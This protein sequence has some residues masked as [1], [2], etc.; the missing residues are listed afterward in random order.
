MDKDLINT[1]SAEVNGE[2]IN[3]LR[4]IENESSE[5]AEV[6]AAEKVIN[7]MRYYRQ[8]CLMK[9]KRR[10]DA[11]R[12]L[13]EE[14]KALLV[15]S[16]TE[17]MKRVRECVEQN[18]KLLEMIVHCGANILGGS[19]QSALEAHQ[20]HPSTEHY[21]TKSKSIL[22][23]L[24]RDWSANGAHERE[25][26]YRLVLNDMATLYPYRSNDNQQN[27]HDI[28]VLVTGA[29]LAR[30]AWE[31]RKMGFSVTG[32]E[33]FSYFMLLTSNFILNACHEKEEFTIYPYVMDFSNSWCYEDQLK[34]IKFP[35]VNPA[36]F[37]DG[38]KNSSERE[39]I[40]NMATGFAMCAGDFLQAYSDAEE[41]FDSV[42]SVFFLD[43]AANP[44]AYIRLIYKILRKGG[45]WLNFGPL[46][47]H[48]ED[49]D[50]TLSLELPFNSILRLVEQCGFKLEKVLDKESQKESPSRYTWNKDSMLQYNYYCGYF[51]AQK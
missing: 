24:V 7:A 20:L 37:N 16:C 41:H 36:D 30:L 12:S 40:N 11:I 22:K 18:Q 5:Q 4:P 42:V 46:T 23:Q 39:N 6:E 17:H 45:F 33:L 2:S 9:L 27:R 25:S 1:F 49:S 50:D 28:Q 38:D 15:A 8:Y 48:H 13:L 26:C 47:Y 51:V 19:V 10:S 35:D 3:K 21:M 32:N 31:L 44:I 34:P 29:G 14:D 43:T